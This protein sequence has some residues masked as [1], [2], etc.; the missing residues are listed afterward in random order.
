MI[1][2]GPVAAARSRKG[3]RV[4]LGAVAVTAAIGICAPPSFAARAVPGCVDFSFS[5]YFR[6]GSAILAPMARTAVA[7]AARHYRRCPIAS[8]T[9]VGLSMPA[10]GRELVER[11]LRA[12]AA[13]LARFGI[14]RPA[15]LIAG[16]ILSKRGPLA[17][18]SADVEIAIAR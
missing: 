13:E 14:K 7:T 4:W 1:L 18:N 11:R 2:N 9:I 15:P 6:P 5:V 3:A 12:V 10:G 16:A 17:A 8:I